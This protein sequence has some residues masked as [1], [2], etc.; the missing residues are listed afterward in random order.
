[1]LVFFF[2]VEVKIRGLVIRKLIFQCDDL[3]CIH[4][5]FNQPLLVCEIWFL[6]ISVTDAYISFLRIK[7]VK[8]RKN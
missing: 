8:L 7:N 1:M 5:Y 3:C 4:H 2:G 6:C